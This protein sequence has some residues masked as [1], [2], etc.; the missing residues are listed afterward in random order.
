MT[1]SLPA[2]QDKNR[3]DFGRLKKGQSGNPEW[4]PRWRSYINVLDEVFLSNKKYNKSTFRSL[5]I[6]SVF[7][8]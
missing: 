5:S 7:K 3:D 8:Q 6:K 2:K 4:R 1:E